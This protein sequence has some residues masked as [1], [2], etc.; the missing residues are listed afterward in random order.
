MFVIGCEV[1]GGVTGHRQSFL[2]EGGRVLE[3]RTR[4]EAQKRLPLSRTTERGVTFNYWI[5][6]VK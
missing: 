4:D 2:K 6:E 1:Y 5:E 3:F